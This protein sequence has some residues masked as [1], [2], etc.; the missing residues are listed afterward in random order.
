MDPPAPSK[1]G[2]RYE[3]KR[4]QVAMRSTTT[5]TTT[6]TTTRTTKGGGGCKIPRNDDVI[7]RHIPPPPPPVGG[8]V[9]PMSTSSSSSRR[10]SGGGKNGNSDEDD[11]DA[12]D[13]GDNDDGGCA[14]IGNEAS[15]IVGMDPRGGSSMGGIEIGGKGTDN[16]IERDD[17]DYEDDD[18]EDEYSQFAVIDDS[19]RSS[20]RRHRR[21][22]E[23]DDD[24]NDDSSRGRPSDQINDR[25]IDH[26]DTATTSRESAWDDDDD[27]HDEEDGGGGRRDTNYDDDVDNAWDKCSRY[28]LVPLLR[29][30]CSPRTRPPCD[31]M[32]ARQGTSPDRIRLI[33]RIVVIIFMIVTIT[34]TCL[35]LLIL[36]RYL[37]V[38]LDNTLAWLLFNPVSGGLAFI[39]VLLL[40]SLCFF[41]IALLSLGAGYVY[42]SIYGLVLGIFYAFLVCYL[43][44]LL[45]AAVC[46]A[47]SR[48]LMRRLIERFS[49]KYPIV[50]AVDRAFE[51]NGFRIFLLLRLSPALP[52]NALVRWASKFILMYISRALSKTEADE[53]DLTM[54]SDFCFAHNAELYRRDYG[55]SL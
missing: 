50:R 15:H 2:A 14:I 44:C 42:A 53:I 20:S 31:A 54:F 52:F 5:T 49:N 9:S 39:G 18:E 11:E 41:P 55:H 1:P 17:D 29:R 38:W 28:C 23:V 4:T 40:G 7:D 3:R 21:D 13:D 51:T 26:R 45:G 24:E 8:V 32:R 12:D 22:G 25:I 27:E 19:T 6:T 33:C 47:R 37:R 16:I 30:T 46:F 35:D 34:F 48:F 43:G 36:H 10:R